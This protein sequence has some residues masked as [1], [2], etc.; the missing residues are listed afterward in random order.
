MPV[1][2]GCLPAA[3]GS[4][5]ESIG[6]CTSQAQGIETG[7]HHNSG[8]GAEDAFQNLHPAPAG[9]RPSHGQQSS[10]LGQQ[11]V[12]SQGSYIGKNQTAPLKGE[13]ERVF[14]VFPVILRGKRLP[15]NAS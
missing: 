14:E 6:V 3:F 5:V 15:H 1:D 10:G 8:Q 11:G 13:H 12:G 7:H 9:N 4:D 2:F